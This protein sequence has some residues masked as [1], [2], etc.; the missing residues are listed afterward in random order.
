MCVSDCSPADI[1]T[2]PV[3][4]FV[5][6]SHLPLHRNFSFC[7]CLHTQL[8]KTKQQINI[9]KDTTFIHTDYW[10][11]LPSDTS[12]RESYFLQENRKK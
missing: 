1:T 8:C 2:K 6:K 11:H 9:N 4:I 12:Q 10:H 7:I 3:L 5:I